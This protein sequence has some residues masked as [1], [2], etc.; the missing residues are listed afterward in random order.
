MS[1]GESIL[2]EVVTR[3]QEIL[4]SG[5]V[6][7]GPDVYKVRGYDIRVLFTTIKR[8]GG[9]RDWTP[10]EE[11]ISQLP[12]PVRGYIVD[13][14]IRIMELERRLIDAASQVRRLE[15]EVER[16]RRPPR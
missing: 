1:G 6:G 2:K 10:N 13:Q 5:Y 14:R 4:R 15:R 16:L 12:S 3:L 7:D 8:Y 11:N 9:R